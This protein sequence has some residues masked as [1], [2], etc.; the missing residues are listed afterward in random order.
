M[1]LI[2]NG[3]I[4]F[5]EIVPTRI[6]RTRNLIFSLQ[7]FLLDSRTFEILVSEIFEYGKGNIDKH[8]YTWVSV[9]KKEQLAPDW[10]KLGEK[11]RKK[12]SA[13]AAFPVRQL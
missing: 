12:S 5:H 2:Y 6:S 9:L 3:K 11:Q 7:E 13:S 8:I 10:N 1:I 4:N